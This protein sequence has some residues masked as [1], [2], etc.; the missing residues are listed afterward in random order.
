MEVFDLYDGLGNKLDKTM[1][2]G[3]S[4]QK[5]EYH[6]VVHIWIRNSKGE[7]LIQQRNKLTDVRPFMWAI[8]G[9]AVTSG[10]DSITGAIRETYEELGLELSRDQ[11]KLLKR[12]Y[13]DAEVGDTTNYITDLYLAETDASIDSLTLDKVEVKDAKFVSMDDIKY[14]IEHNEFWNYERLLE[15]QGLL[16]LLEKS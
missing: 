7:Y 1:I 16:T 6:L 2:R 12:Y 13:I 10:E 14:M 4:N 3:T 15:R 8:T 11:I 9:G 5:G